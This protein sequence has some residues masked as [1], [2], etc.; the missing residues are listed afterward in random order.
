M[1]QSAEWTDL[2]LAFQTLN[3]L[4]AQPLAMSVPFP[5]F[6]DDY[7]TISW[8]ARDAYY[9]HYMALA[10]QAHIPALNFQAHDQDR[11]FLHDTGAHYTARGWVFADRAID[12]FW[13][14]HSVAEIHAALQSLEAAAPGKTLPDPARA[15]YCR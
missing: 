11:Y 15:G 3:E 1:E 6:Y 4:G 12:L 13:H 9:Q 8:A 14:G 2:W 10:A 7:T 5:G